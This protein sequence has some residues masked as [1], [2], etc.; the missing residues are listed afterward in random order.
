MGESRFVRTELN[1]LSEKPIP[2]REIAQLAGL[3]RRAGL[4]HIGIRLLNPIV[5][6]T[7]KRP[8]VATGVEKAEYAECLTRIGASDEALQILRSLTENDAPQTHLFTASAYISQW[9]YRNAIPL[10]AKYIRSPHVDS[11]WRLVGK[12]NLAAALAYER[13]FTKSIVLLREILYETSLRQ[14]D[15]LYGNALEV[16]AQTYVAQKNWKEA[17]RLLKRARVKLAQTNTR[18]QFFVQKWETIT[19]FWKTKA[20]P[21]SVRQLK[22]LRQRA[23]SLHHWETVRQCDAHMAVALGKQDLFLQLYFGTPFPSFREHLIA[24]FPTAVILPERY[25]WNIGKS[26][27]D[28]VIFDLMGGARIG[29]KAGLK[30]GQL[31]HR[32]LTL[33]C[34][35]FYRPVRV[36]TLHQALYPDEHFNPVTSPARVHEAVRRLRL[37]FQQT[38]L[39][40]HIEEEDGQYRFTGKEGTALIVRAPEKI[41]GKADLLW[42]ESLRG[43]RPMESFSIQEAAN[44]LNRSVRTTLRLLDEA[45]K[46]GELFR[47][48]HS[49]AT[50]YHFAPEAGI[51][52]K[53]S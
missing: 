22:T 6:P 16:A 37:W 38:R 34:R 52:K 3:A 1:H 32:L 53:A 4:T 24:D 43:E 11:Y 21:S 44:T 46:R 8:M 36:P 10:L 35:D 15:L 12:I 49:R 50:R 17:S 19:E 7:P 30:V 2:R 29:K 9:D 47:S 27:R 26:A 23:L 40:F 25:E 28:N 14:L 42:I 51:V 31:I 13:T 41:E 18:D 48:G 45:I 39:P 20:A 5:R 33:L